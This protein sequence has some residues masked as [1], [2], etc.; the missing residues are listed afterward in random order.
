MHA[1]KAL[2]NFGGTPALTWPVFEEWRIHWLC[3]QP[4]FFSERKRQLV[5]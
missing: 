4:R 2:G 3:G 5:L 1:R